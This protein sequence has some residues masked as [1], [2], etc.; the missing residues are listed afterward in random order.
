MDDLCAR[1]YYALAYVH[2]SYI[3]VCDIEILETHEVAVM[4]LSILGSKGRHKILGDHLLI[5]ECVLKGLFYGWS[6]MYL[7]TVRC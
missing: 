4:V 7:I 1:N 6:Q 5:I 3:L 2:V